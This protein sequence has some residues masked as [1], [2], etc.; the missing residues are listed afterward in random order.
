MV[1]GVQVQKWIPNFFSLPKLAHNDKSMQQSKLLTSAIEA[2]KK[3]ILVW[4]SLLKMYPQWPND[5]HLLKVHCTLQLGYESFLHRFWEQYPYPIYISV[6]NSNIGNPEWIQ[7]FEFSMNGELGLNNNRGAGGETPFK[8]YC[9][10]R[11]LQAK[12]DAR[13]PSPIVHTPWK[14]Y[15]AVIRTSQ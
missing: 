9:R 10:S 2:Q 11:K 6:E 14:S 1:L 5:F 3:Q 8:C 15:P 7:I 13:N 12:H 4:K